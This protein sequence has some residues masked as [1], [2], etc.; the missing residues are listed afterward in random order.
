MATEFNTVSSMFEL[1][2][3]AGNIP[4]V[5]DKAT[6]KYRP[7]TTDDFSLNSDANATSLDSF[8]RLRVSNPVTLFDSTHR[9]R[10]N[11]LW[12]TST[13]GTASATFN[14]DQG[15][16]DMTVDN[17]SGSQV[18]RETTKVFPYQ[19]GKSLMIMSTFA[20]DSVKTGLR[21][22]VGYFGTQ[23][24]VYLEKDNAEVSF[25]ERTSVSGSLVENKIL[26]EDW[27]VD[28]MD[29]TGRSGVTLD[30][31]KAQI[32]WSD[33]EWLGVGTVRIGFI[34]DGKYIHCHSFHHANQIAT[35]YITT[36]TLP[37]RY[38]ITNTAA[39]SG[40]SNLKQICS[41]VISE[42]GYSLQGEQRSA[43]VPITGSKS[44][45]AAGT[46]TPVVS[47]RLKTGYI[48]AAAILSAVNLVGKTNNAF[49]EWQLISKGVSLGGSFTS[50]TTSSVEY[51][52]DGTGITGGHILAA[53]YFASTTQSQQSVSIDR[54]S[55]LRFKL[56]RNSFENYTYEMTLAC[57]SD[58]SSADVF[59]SMDWEEISR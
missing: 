49:Y 33:F 28:K 40:S 23:N 31:S 25:V 22:R 46:N 20:M 35:T 19:P 54:D 45:G 7:L 2:K 6:G 5:L 14:A 18:I 59:G 10:D 56:E 8:G 38:E 39:T 15:L 27:N 53:G 44:I 41:S 57:A 32:L 37:L 1:S 17:S 9:Y 58:T 34:V 13:N 24:G 11:E 30:L 50:D 48:D 43:A 29:G 36:A 16:I 52:L 3:Q 26:Q 55:L 51:K 21:Q 47:V 4:H 42:G 12:S